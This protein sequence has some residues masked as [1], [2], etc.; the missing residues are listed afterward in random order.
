MCR[1]LGVIVRGAGDWCSLDGESFHLLVPCLGRCEPAEDLQG[2][3]V[4]PPGDLVELVLGHV[5]QACA[6][7]QVT[8]DHTVAVLSLLPR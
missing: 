7:G 4:D 5:V 1:G 8:A 3:A 2:R 6:L